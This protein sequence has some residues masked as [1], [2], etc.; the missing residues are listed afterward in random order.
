[1]GLFFQLSSVF[2]LR[3]VWLVS[4][5]N[6]LAGHEAPREERVMFCVEFFTGRSWVLVGEYP[7]ES[8]AE[9]SAAYVAW[10]RKSGFKFMNL[11]VESV[12]IRDSHGRRYV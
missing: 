6:S 7:S 4:I 8:E 2:R 11:H 12:S 1:M 9:E 5:T 3:P 10:H